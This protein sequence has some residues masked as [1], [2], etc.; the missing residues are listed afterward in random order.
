[1]HIGRGPLTFADYQR[2]Y[3]VLYAT[4]LAAEARTHRA[5]IFFSVVGTAILRKDHGLEA[6]IVAGAAAYAF[7]AAGRQL[8]SF[9]RLEGDLFTSGP[10]AFH[11][12][13]ECDG[14]AI[15]FMAP[16]FQESVR[17]DGHNLT[18]PRRMFQKPVTAAATEMPDP[19]QPG[20]FC[21]V[22]D[23]ART[24]DVK[25][26][27]GAAEMNADLGSLAMAWYKPPPRKIKAEFQFNDTEGLRTAMLRAPGL[28]GAW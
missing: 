15:D 22:P 5:C 3:T 17:A 13:V 18:V 28:V 12:W 23:Q 9:G 14:F 27:F 21:L 19:G 7:D 25:A 10:N 4:L 26:A 20:A 24:D 2:I 1:M 16:I 8:V 6:Q 11:A